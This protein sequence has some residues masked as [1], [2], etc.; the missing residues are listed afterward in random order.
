MDLFSLRLSLEREF[1]IRTGAFSV[2][3]G[4]YL[5]T[6]GT[7]QE[8]SLDIGALLSGRYLY[9]DDLSFYLSARRGRFTQSVGAGVE[10][11]L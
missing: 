5:G 1:S 10:V 4:G 8:V 9:N 2:L 6:V 7:S 11:E 3:P